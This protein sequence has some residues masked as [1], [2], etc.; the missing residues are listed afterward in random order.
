MPSQNTKSIVLSDSTYKLLAQVRAIFAQE[1]SRAQELDIDTLI[2]I[3]ASGFLES[4]TQE[5]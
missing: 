3:L 4:E 1:D 5:A 2:A